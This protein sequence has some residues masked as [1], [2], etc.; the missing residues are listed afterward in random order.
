MPENQSLTRPRSEMRRLSRSMRER[1]YTFQDATWL[2][3]HIQSGR[4]ES[5]SSSSTMKE[6]HPMPT[7]P[8][9]SASA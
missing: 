8:S 9:R 3:L 6:I 7:Q 1:L 4:D 5:A 2:N